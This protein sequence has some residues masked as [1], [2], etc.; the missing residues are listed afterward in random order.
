MGDVEQFQEMAP[1]LF[2]KKPN[3]M[4]YTGVLTG[5]GP[6]GLFPK[7]NAVVVHKE[8]LAVSSLIAW[9]VISII[10]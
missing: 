10:W 2:V 4:E 9:R 5:V 8:L 6:V 7:P 1:V 3:Y